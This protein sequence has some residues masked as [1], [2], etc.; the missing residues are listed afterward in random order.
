MRVE[1]I[2]DAAVARPREEREAYVAQACDG[3]DSLRAEVMLLLASAE[4]AWN[5]MGND[6]PSPEMESEF[7]RLK[8]E[9]AGERIGRYKLREQIGEGGFGT[10]WVADQEEPVK[11]RVALKVIKLGM[12]TKEVIA[13]FEQER[14]ALA[15]MD[16]P[17]IAKVLDAGATEWGRPFFVMELVRGIKITDYCDQEN[18]PTDE[19][20]KLFVA[21]CNAVQHA[22]QKGIIHRDLK[23][24]NILVTLHDG[25][26]V[27]KIIDFG[28]AKA[29]QGR[30]TDLTIYT[31]FQQM[32]GT[33]L[34]MSPEQAEMTGMDVDTRSDI[35]SLGVLLY[36]LLTG[37]TPVAADTLRRVGLDEIRRIIREQESPRPSTA[38]HTMGLDDRTIIAHRH[39]VEPPKLIGLLRGDLDSITLKALEKNRSHRYETANGLAMDV[40]RYLANE[41]VVARP[42]SQLYRFGRIARR[43]KAVFFAGV[44]V[45][46]T[47][48]IGGTVAGWQARLAGRALLVSEQSLDALRATAPTFFAVSQQL[49]MEQKLDDALEKIGFAIKLEPGNADY[50]L[51][52]AH[53]LQLAL[54]LP[55][56]NVAYH[57]VLELRPHDGAA[58]ENTRL[59]D[60]IIAASSGANPLPRELQIKLADTLLIQNRLIEAGQLNMRL[61]RDAPTIEPALRAALLN[62]RNQQGWRDDRLNVVNAGTFWLDLSGLKIGDLSELQGYPITTFYLNGCRLTRLPNLRGLPLD[63][64]SIMQNLFSDIEPLRGLK[65]RELNLYGSP[66]TDVSALQG[67]P[68]I[69]INLMETDVADLSPLKGAPLTFIML[70]RGVFDLAPLQKAPLRAVYMNEIPCSDLSPLSLSPLELLHCSSAVSDL[71][72]IRHLKDLRELSLSECNRISDFS[73]LLDCPKL[74]TLILPER[75]DFSPLRNHTGLKSISIRVRGKGLRNGLDGPMSP[76]DF[77]RKYDTDS[78]QRAADVAL[79]ERVMAAIGPFQI[80]PDRLDSV[81]VVNGKVE[82]DLSNLQI[83][84]LNPLRGLPITKLNLSGTQV[85]DLSPLLNLPIKELRLENTRISDL[86]PLAER[87]LE[88]LRC[89]RSKRVTDLTPLAQCLTLKSLSVAGTSVRSLEAIRGLQLAHLGCASTAVS[90][91]SPIREMPLKQIHFA[92]TFV[93]DVTPLSSCKSLEDI[94]LS[95]SVWNVEILRGL[96]TLRFISYDYALRDRHAVQTSQEFWAEYDSPINRAEWK[97]TWFASGG[98]DPLTSLE[99]WRVNATKLEAV[100]ATVNRLNFEYGDDGPRDLNLSPELNERGPSGDDFGMIARTQIVLPAGKWR[101]KLLSDDGSRL[102]VNGKMLIEMWQ[103]Q[104]AET[105]SA[106]FSQNQSGPVDFVVEHFEGAGFA[107]LKFTIEPLE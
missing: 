70:N 95:E 61:G 52:R 35:Y 101:F 29:T 51:F 106:D 103:S 93:S 62:Y 31:Q 50:W 100:S 88:L 104:H 66:V 64:L 76:A 43:N 78:Q 60:E 5:L 49:M 22:H 56:A 24:S 63:N 40:Q 37:R 18:L 44:T 92:R 27:P 32:I 94:Q 73:P 19:R 54:R 75:G 9:E 53:T 55:E 48:L 28:V 16:H 69:N 65:L 107:K 33:P 4:G 77:W 1:A 91:L 83:L 6:P 89:G 20:L 58:R 15:L 21:V 84:D 85:V 80:P 79:R 13:R 2:F 12:D 45:F 36:E 74:Q 67:M 10:V 8:P 102:I 46:L 39:R 11:R 17:N 59:C 72:P 38:L 82:L 97:V 41:P 14:Q 25:E 30:L 71:T 68:L 47:V 42:T 87:P 34:Y 23:P 90:D 7:S 86:S 105:E 3:D 96:P 98:V 99:A 57:R 26:P 81:T